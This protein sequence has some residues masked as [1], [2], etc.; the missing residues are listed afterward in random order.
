MEQCDVL[1]IGAG[2]I[3][4]AVAER[5]SRDG[6]SEIVVV[7]RHE[8]FG[9]E[10]SSRNSEVI[11]AGFYYL[12][13]SLKARLCVEG[14][15][16]LYEFLER[17]EIPHQRCGK[18]VVGNS[19]AEIDKIDSLFRLGTANGVE[20]LS[21]LTPEAVRRLEPEVVAAVGM[22]SPATGIFDSH[23]FMA[24]LERQSLDR[25]VLLAY[26][27]EVRGI[28]RTSRGYQVDIA[29]ADGQPLQMA[30]EV[31]VNA[32]GLG[33][34]AIA[35]M[36]GIDVLAEGYR[37]YPC[38]GE[39]FGVHPR[40]RGRLSRLIYPAPTAI[41][42]GIHTVLSLDGSM[43]L[44]P[45]AFYVDEMNYAVDDSHRDEFFEEARTY[46]PFL[47]RDDLA[48]DTAGIRPKRQPQGSSAFADFL[49]REESSRGLPGFVNLVGLESP[50]LTSSLAVAEYVRGLLG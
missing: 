19:R 42:L 1:I 41:S 23:R 31:V 16:L 8:G 15:H 6:R 50:G 35:G 45:N 48:A 24:C 7:E 10:T 30:A 4:L 17:N 29:D 25:G 38:K 20:E 44:G 27:C 28:A 18:I 12:T 49:I 43:R 46:L 47:T 26:H 34:D 21:L 36:T 14:R 5:L 2:A 3:G 39:Y 37:L 11:H 32:A 33:S 40:H 9:R 13:G 22:L